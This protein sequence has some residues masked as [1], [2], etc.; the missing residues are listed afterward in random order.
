[1]N[2]VQKFEQRFN[3]KVNIMHEVINIDSS[4]K[5]ITVK[6]LISGEQFKD[7]YDKLII[8]TGSTS[9]IINRT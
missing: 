3:I 9:I 1:M 7:Y 4:E 8:A 6:N 2:T 5:S